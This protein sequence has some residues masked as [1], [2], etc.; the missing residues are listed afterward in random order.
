MYN[1]LVLTTDLPFFP[2][3]MGVDFFNLRYAAQHHAV[4]V[5]GPLHPQYPVDGVANLERFLSGAYFWPRP[6]ATSPPLPPLKDPPRHLRGWLKSL[7][8]GVRKSWLFGLLGLRHQPPDAYGQLATL[9]NCAPYLLRALADR[10]WHV[11]A[12]IQSNTEPWL[13]YLPSQPAKFVYFHDV[14]ADYLERQ[15][16]ISGGDTEARKKLEAIFA[17]EQRY[18]QRAESVAFVSELD[19]RRAVNLF[20]PLADAGVSPLPVDTDYYA[21]A[22]AGWSKDRRPI[23][24]FTGHLGH[25]PNVDA[26]RYFLEQIWP[27]VQKQVPTAVFQVVGMLPSPEVQQACADAP[28]VELHP[29][30]PDIRPYFWNASVY[31]VPM[32]FGGGVRQ[33]I[34]EAWSMELPVVCTSM[35]VEGTRAVDGQ[36]CQLADNPADFAAHVMEQLRAPSRILIT[37]AKETVL[38]HNSIPAAAGCYEELAERAVRRKWKRTYKLLFDLR[39]MKIGKAGGSEQM[40]YELISEISRL[41]HRNEYRIH[42]P[43]STYYEWEFPKNFRCRGF[44]TESTE[45]RF[46]ALRAGMANQLA[47]TVRRPPL[48]TPEMRA[49]RRY[50]E[51]D[52]DLVHSTCNYSFPEMR[53]FPHILTMLDLQHVHYPEFFTPEA[54]AERD[55]LYRVSANQAAHLMCI[56]E[57]TRQDVHKS[58]GIPL[59]KM[60][61]IWIIPSRTAWIK[62]EERQRNELLARMGLRGRFLFYPAH[63]W[64][65]KNHRRLV[66]A[67]KMVETELPS[68]MQLVFTGRQFDE[69]HPARQLIG[70]E[71]LRG[72]VV[73]LGY[74]SPLEIRALYSGARALVFPSLFEGFGMPVAEA[75]IA[76]CP[77]ACSAATSLPEIAGDAAIYFDPNNTKD[78]ARKLLAVATDEKL[79]ANLLAAGRQRKP[80][81]SS[82]LS[83]VKALSIY[84][85]VFEEVYSP[86]GLV[87]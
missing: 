29:N 28:A 37:R 2:G 56:S 49:L 24:L 48:L 7:P 38:A 20:H 78:M 64:P 87:S 71:K 39:W 80:L 51:L 42:C 43:R 15:T 72:R 22:P 75:I 70:A 63:S 12:L 67:F 54:W 53:A 86:S 31:I 5:V 66:E 32:R 21:P 8:F 30:V 85:R 74:R 40:S 47:E 83:A 44:F 84:R 57:Y 77:V 50:N 69:Q 17:Q 3:K 9:A 58:Y 76:D 10:Q 34:F 35:A 60:T 18:C 27:L 4:G 26:V 33:K 62:V 6:L 45:A 14:R 25:A 82:R 11:L 41:D 52:F 23:V 16:K 68:D 73:H 59:E 65:H 1:I 36:N 13:D 55:N 19:L 81:F 61:T 46:S 79:R